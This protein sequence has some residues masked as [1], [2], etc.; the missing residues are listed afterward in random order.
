[1]AEVVQVEYPVSIDNTPSCSPTLADVVADV[2]LNKE[3]A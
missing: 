3:T 2:E 1:M